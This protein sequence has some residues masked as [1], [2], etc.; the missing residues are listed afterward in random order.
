MARSRP[1]RNSTPPPPDRGPV[2]VDYTVGEIIDHALL[3][4]NR[5]GNTVAKPIIPRKPPFITIEG[6]P[7]NFNP[8]K[9]D[10]EVR[11]TYI[12][13]DGEVK[14]VVVNPPEVVA[15]I[16]SDMQAW[17]SKSVDAW[18]PFI[19]VEAHVG[20]VKIKNKGGRNEFFV[21]EPHRDDGPMPID[22]KILN[23]PQNWRPR[24]QDDTVG[25]Q[26]TE[27][28][29]S[30]DKKSVWGR[31]QAV[32]FPEVEDTLKAD[33]EMQAKL[34]K[35]QEIIN[36]DPPYD[37]LMERIH[38]IPEKKAGRW[39]IRD[40]SMGD[41][42][43]ADECRLDV[44]ADWN[45][46]QLAQGKGLETTTI[47]I[48]GEPEY[49]AEVLV[50]V[51]QA[52]KVE[53]G[54]LLVLASI[55]GIEPP[56]KKTEAELRA[57]AEAA[58]EAARKAREAAA[59]PPER[60]I[61]TR[62]LFDGLRA[63]VTP[64]NEALIKPL[65]LEL[66]KPEMNEPKQW[67]ARKALLEKVQAELANV[68]AALVTLVATDDEAIEKLRK[69]PEL[70]RGVAAEIARVTA[71]IERAEAVIAPEREALLAQLALQRSRRIED[72]RRTKSRAAISARAEER[73]YKLRNETIGGTTPP[74]G[75]DDI[76]DVAELR[77]LQAEN[78]A[79]LEQQRAFIEENKTPIKVGD[80]DY[81]LSEYAEDFLV[82]ELMIPVF[83]ERIE[84]EERAAA[85]QPTIDRTPPPPAAGDT[86]APTPVP[87]GRPDAVPIPA[88]ATGVEPEAVLEGD[89]LEDWF[90]TRGFVVG[91]AVHF[92]EKSLRRWSKL[93]S[94]G[95]PLE[96]RLEIYS[97]AV[98]ENEIE[99]ILPGADAIPFIIPA[100][101]LY[102]LARV[103]AVLAHEIETEGVVDNCQVEF[104]REAVD[105]LIK[106]ALRAWLGEHPGSTLPQT[107]R[108]K[109]ADLVSERII[110]IM[111]G[112]ADIQEIAVPM[113]GFSRL[114]K[115]KNIIVV[116]G[117]AGVE[118]GIG[119]RTQRV[120]ETAP[121]K[122]KLSATVKKGAI[123]RYE[124]EGKALKKGGTFI[125]FSVDDDK[126]EVV[127]ATAAAVAEAGGIDRAKKMR[128]TR[129]LWHGLPKKLVSTPP[130]KSAPARL[131][132][133]V[134]APRAPTAVAPAIARPPKVV[135]PPRPEVPPAE[136][137]APAETIRSVL[138]FLQATGGIDKVQAAVKKAS[139]FAGL[140]VLDPVKTMVDDMTKAAV[141]SQASLAKNKTLQDQAQ[142]MGSLDLRDNLAHAAAVYKQVEAE[143]ATEVREMFNEFTRGRVPDRA[144]DRLNAQ[145]R[146]VNDAL[147]T[148]RSE[149]DSLAQQ[150]HTPT[151]PPAP[152][153]TVVRRRGST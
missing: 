69:V 149:Q 58:R 144:Q 141:Q 134:P 42:V 62:A 84:D 54:K 66:E 88:P 135:L 82:A 128:A 152:P 118:L 106:P 109:E 56:P 6:V 97:M 103:R 27:V 133:K 31:A 120:K 124:G 129:D 38:F 13:R 85:G 139:F 33:Q 115:A 99:L 70:V 78:A 60:P 77:R 79:V 107:A 148:L 59:R 96:D 113:E 112:V 151:P 93:F 25:I 127:I 130:E 98:G 65:V 146:R 63:V 57:E 114:L 153:S 150:L 126:G 55:N 147:V 71:E 64:A 72:L 108:V 92:P 19:G 91:A 140:G 137:R 10:V 90:T 53:G 86:G 20:G 18:K 95:S 51:P 47:E 29:L 24:N 7:P 122:E 100:S 9:K 8:H 34:V 48:S 104:K 111:A 23:L 37:L 89:Q 14:G 110:L 73:V 121:E 74:V 145:L 132:P 131:S 11:V 83:A 136:S 46:D 16:E 81:E 3:Q 44:P 76:H 143:A 30:G 116:P 61:S 80:D 26:L 125:V 117:P 67:K 119:L 12:R 101:E 142:A 4:T 52:A 39:I 45:P 105:A 2:S 68:R 87:A 21:Y 32:D 5:D 36:T 102:D 40:F 138:T 41:G 22:I 94:A 50:I 1:P 17:A 49:E 75:L 43:T 28:L 123:Y 35:A 15:Q